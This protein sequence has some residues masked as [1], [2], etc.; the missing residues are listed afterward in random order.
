MIFIQCVRSKSAPVVTVA[1]QLL[2]FHVPWGQTGN[3]RAD[4]GPC[5]SSGK[6]PSVDWWLRHWQSATHLNFSNLLP[7]FS[8]LLQLVCSASAFLIHI[9]SPDVPV[10][11]NTRN[12]NPSAVGQTPS[13]GS[14]S[15][16]C[17]TLETMWGEKKKDFLAFI[18]Q[19]PL[20]KFI[21]QRAKHRV[22]TCQE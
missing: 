3:R 2:C 19:P 1:L 6:V 18:L 17:S 7:D 20:C 16:L 14:P 15:V 10:H 22:N 5:K 21:A 11:C 13:P 12:Q 8:L 9:F 4:P